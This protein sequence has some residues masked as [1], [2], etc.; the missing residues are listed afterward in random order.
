[1]TPVDRP[2]TPVDHEFA[3]GGG[4]SRNSNA[5]DNLGAR[6]SDC[7]HIVVAL[8]MSEPVLSVAP[9]VDPRHPEHKAVASLPSVEILGIN[10]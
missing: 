9:D 6:R 1:M 3:G 2:V 10:S 7:K 4:S 8:N 5:N